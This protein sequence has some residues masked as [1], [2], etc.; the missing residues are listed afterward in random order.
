MRDLVRDPEPS[1]AD[2]IAEPKRVTKKTSQRI[3]AELACI[4]EE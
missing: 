3:F 1:I 2:N 4:G